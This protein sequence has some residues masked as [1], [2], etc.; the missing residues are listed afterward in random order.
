MIPEISPVSLTPINSFPPLV[1]ANETNERA[2]LAASLTSNLKSSCLPSPVSI[3]LSILCFFAMVYWIKTLSFT[4]QIII[5]KTQYFL[6]S[7]FFHKNDNQV[8]FLR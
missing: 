8:S 2:I 6:S 1:F 7:W 4:F 5:N 3:R